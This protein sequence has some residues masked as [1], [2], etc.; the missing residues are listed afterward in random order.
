VANDL[1]LSLEFVKWL[2]SHAKPR[3]L[4]P[5]PIEKCT[6]VFTDGAA[7][8]IDR[9]LVSTGAVIFSPRLKSPQFFS[10]KLP[11]PLVQHWQK[12]G[13]KQVI[14]QAEIYPV[15]QSKRAWARELQHA[16]VVWLIDNESARE[17]LV[18]SY[19]NSWSARELLFLNAINDMATNSA[20]WYARV[21]S[22]ANVADEPSRGEFTLMN[23][24]KAFKVSAPEIHKHELEAGLEKLVSNK[25]C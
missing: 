6:L 21:P 13:S 25:G 23:K 11:S 7:E 16:R 5:R 15:L 2:V 19:S 24:L 8:G 4:I 3:V 18:K 20:N 22:C 1:R 17:S 14:C 10:Y 9:Q 12:E